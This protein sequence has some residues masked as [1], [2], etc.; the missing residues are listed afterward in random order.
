MHQAEVEV[1]VVVRVGPGD[2]RG[3]R[4]PEHVAHREVA[5]PGGVHSLEFGC[6]SMLTVP[7]AQLLVAGFTENLDA[8]WSATPDPYRIFVQTMG[9]MTAERL[10]EVVKEVQCISEQVIR[11]TLTISTVKTGLFKRR[12]IQVARRFGH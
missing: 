2:G 12:V 1:A 6:H 7:L 10:V 11:N 3:V 9:A 4:G 5:G 8:A